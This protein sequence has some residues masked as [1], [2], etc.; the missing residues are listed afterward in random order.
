MERVPSQGV[1]A[2][3]IRL[4]KFSTEAVVALTI[5][6]VFALLSFG[7]IVREQ[8]QP[9]RNDQSVYIAASN[10]TTNNADALSV[11]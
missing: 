6:V 5:A 1:A 4:M 11:Y 10:V 7:A 2:K 8:G 3:H 9:A